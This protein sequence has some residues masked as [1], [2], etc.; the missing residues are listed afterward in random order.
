MNSNLS[1]LLQGQVF[2]ALIVVAVAIYALNAVLIAVEA[3]Y[4]LW[5]RFVLGCLQG[6]GGGT[7]R[8]FLIGGNRMPLFY[9]RDPAFLIAILTVVAIVSILSATKVDFH[10]SAGF[11][12][13]KKY[14]DIC[15]FA[16]LATLGAC[17]GVG[18][19]FPW[20]W[21]PIFAAL[22]C[23]GGGALRDIAIMKAPTSFRGVIFEEVAAFGGLVLFAALEIDERFFSTDVSIAVAVGLTVA[24]IV[25]LRLLI[26]AYKL[27]Y[28]QWLLYKTRHRQEAKAPLDMVLG[29]MDAQVRTFLTHCGVNWT[30]SREILTLASA[31]LD[32]CL[33]R[34][35]QRQTRPPAS[36]LRRVGRPSPADPPRPQRRAASHRRRSRTT[37]DRNRRP[38]RRTRDS[39][40]PELRHQARNA[41]RW[42]RSRNRHDLRV[43]QNKGMLTR[44]SFVALASLSLAACTKSTGPLPPSTGAPSITKTDDEWFAQL[45]PQQFYV[46]RNAATDPPFSGSMHQSHEKGEFHCI[47]CNL[48][49]FSSKDKYDSGTGWPGFTRPVALENLRSHPGDTLQGGVELRCSRCDAHLGHIF[50]DG[51]APDHLR[52]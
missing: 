13:V 27:Q 37:L 38:H 30:I 2:H 15:G 3:G 41:S 25:T 24:T 1:E 22:S 26:L 36:H 5:G 9:T 17:I 39:H 52:Y 47:C 33:N 50:D 46:T 42:Q 14:A 8:D 45:T 4:D 16:L 7:I 44:R 21:I 23:A 19:N 18:A 48:L 10:Q 43:A 31:S 20:F 34:P 28:P 12:S 11:Q 40:D 32:E 35:A 6:L 49:L 29:E 51:P